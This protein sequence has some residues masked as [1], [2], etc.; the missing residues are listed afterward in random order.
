M[1]RK[2]KHK[3]S[4]EPKIQPTEENIKRAKKYKEDTEQKIHDLE[5]EIM[6]YGERVDAMRSDPV[7]LDAVEASQGRK[8]PS[9]NFESIRKPRRRGA[10]SQTRKKIKQLIKRACLQSTSDTELPNRARQKTSNTT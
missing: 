2:R 3:K 9:G 10:G 6:K 8:A 7:Y 4:Q 1:A 5:E